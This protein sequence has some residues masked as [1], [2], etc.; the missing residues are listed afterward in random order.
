MEYFVR[1]PNKFIKC[2]IEKD[3]GVTPSFYIAYHLLSNNRNAKNQSFISIKEI[4]DIY[5]AKCT[6][7]KPKIFKDIVTSI[8]K[9]EELGLVCSLNTP[10]VLRYESFLKYQL[11]GSF[12]P[13]DDYT[14]LTEKELLNI[15]NIDSATT[16][17]ILL[18][19]FLYIKANL[20]KRLPD[21]E[22]S[23]EN[24]E[25]FFKNI[26]TSAEEIGIH[27][28]TFYSAIEELCKGDNP[29][30]IKSK[31]IHRSSKNNNVC[32]PRAIVINKPGWEEDLNN[33]VLALRNI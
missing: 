23:P 4:M 27:Y 26:K 13:F 8:S 19:V 28:N 11:C 7:R 14:V 6:P 24:P 18:L 31:V 33:A 15:M 30:L 22:K 12:D 3:F 29:L 20:T 5:S 16:K 32:S 9:M 25:A 10:S 2:N 1:I 17:D 21:Q